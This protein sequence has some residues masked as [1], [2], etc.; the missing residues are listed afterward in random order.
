MKLSLPLPLKNVL[1]N[2][3]FFYSVLIGVIYPPLVLLLDSIE[4]G[5]T[6][7]AP[8]QFFTTDTFYYLTIARHSANKPFYTADG[9]FPTNGFHP[10]WEFLLTSLFQ[11]RTFAGNDVSQMLLV[12]GISLVLVAI[13]TILFAFVVYKLTRNF[14][15]ALLASVPGFYYLTFVSAITPS[16]NSVWAYMNGMESPLSI[17]LFGITLYLLINKKLLYHPTIPAMMIL[18]LMIT[19]LIFS[20]LDNAFLLIPYLG[21]LYLF[22]DHKKEALI[23][24]SI[25]AA[26]PGITLLI[27]LSYNHAQYG[28]FLPVSGMIKQGNYFI[29]NF[30][31]FITSF[32]AVGLINARTLW[33]ETTMR[34]LQMCVPILLA[35][36]WLIHFQK[37][38]NN[39]NWK[40][41]ARNHYI[42]TILIFLLAYVII[43][44]LYNLLFVFLMAQGHW[45]YPLSI[46][47]INLMIALF[48]AGL[49]RKTSSSKLL[50]VINVAAVLAV[51][52]YANS[53]VDYKETSKYNSEFYALWT[54]KKTAN[55]QLS[56]INTNMKIVEYDDGILSYLLNPPTMNG[57]GYTLDYEAYKAQITGHFLELAYARGFNVIGVMDYIKLPLNIDNDSDQI[58]VVLQNMAGIRLENLNSWTF[59]IIY[60][61]PNT[62]A[63]FIEFRKRY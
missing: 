39:G 5:K 40:S 7:L 13:G 6:I 54:Q 32:I 41:W 52:L 2:V 8:I 59:K 1:K 22:S 48:L 19:L 61:V 12:F 36:P 18:S 24:I 38:I 15:V 45:Y 31:Y 25:S 53:F 51:L 28:S 16:Y 3:I 10:L 34:A 47:I 20:R 55:Q 9:L 60:R 4:R 35:I 23:R 29:T 57:F 49:L 56:K 17:C 33:S 37:S 26:L 14:A 50:A 30:G 63:A 44:G 62:N 42:K 43:M 58:R 21:M 11:L 27:Y 46:M